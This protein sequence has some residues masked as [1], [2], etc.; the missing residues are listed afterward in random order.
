MLIV[1]N[2]RVFAY[3][4]VGVSRSEFRRRRLRTGSNNSTT[5][6]DGSVRRR[7]A[8]ISRCGSSSGR[9]QST[10]WRWQVFYV[11]RHWLLVVT[12]DEQVAVV[13]RGAAPLSDVPAGRPRR[14]GHLLAQTTA[15]WPVP[16]SRHPLFRVL[17]PKSATAT[18][19]AEHHLHRPTATVLPGR[20]RRPDAACG[21]HGPLRAAGR[22]ET[23]STMWPGRLHDA[24]G[25]GVW[26]TG[27]WS[28]L[29]RCWSC[30]VW[31]QRIYDWSAQT[32]LCSY[33][34]CICVSEYVKA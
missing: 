23:A 30:F 17:P 5:T 11:T 25:R 7:P 32:R 28:L 10:G 13:R 22:R 29:Q 19:V 8:E 15:T 2:L 3:V 31:Q 9:Q 34:L 27:R 24:D 1:K 16:H 14:R 12:W 33:S 21:V 20:I 4:V 6:F 18:S 26:R